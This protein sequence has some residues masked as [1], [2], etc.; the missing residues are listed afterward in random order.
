VDRSAGTCVGSGTA[1]TPS[2]AISSSSAFADIPMTINGGAKGDQVLRVE[3]PDDV[4][5]SVE[6]VE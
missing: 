1:A 6:G 2:S 4:D 5:L 3:F